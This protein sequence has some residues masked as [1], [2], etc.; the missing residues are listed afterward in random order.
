MF[1]PKLEK[2]P[3]KGDRLHHTRV[4]NDA[5]LGRQQLR[6]SLSLSLSRS[7][8][9]TQST[10]ERIAQLVIPLDNPSAA[11]LESVF[12]NAL[13]GGKASHLAEM[14]AHAKVAGG[15]DDAARGLVRVPAASVVTTRAYDAH[16]AALGLEA[17]LQ[18]VLASGDVAQ[19]PAI[20]ARILGP[21]ASDELLG[22]AVRNFLH[23]VPATVQRFAVRS[24]ST[25]EDQG[26]NSFAGQYET[27]LN[28]P[29]GGTESRFCFWRV[30]CPIYAHSRVNRGVHQALLGF[31]VGG[32]PHCVS[33][34]C[35]LQIRQRVKHGRGH[36]ATSQQ[37]CRRCGFLT[38]SRDGRARRDCR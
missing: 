10:V 34:K 37:R 21:A 28:V 15:G 3:T 1:A 32:A 12:A 35:G 38:E 7:E 23:T 33:C 27:C 20:R 9:L 5:A 30:F 24:S 36:P 13:V 6:E 22:I 8:D 17:Q 19:L 26:A 4:R 31:D 29:R 25:A 11:D 18:Q 16:I 2:Q 14:I